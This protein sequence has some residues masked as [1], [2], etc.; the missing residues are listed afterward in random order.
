MKL[1]LKEIEESCMILRMLVRVLR[2]QDRLLL[3]LRL[4]Q[5]LLRLRLRLRLSWLNCRLRQ[6][7]SRKEV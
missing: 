5:R 4:D 6:E 2:V 3:K 7:R 1:L